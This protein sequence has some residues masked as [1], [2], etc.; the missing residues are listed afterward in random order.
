MMTRTDHAGDIEKLREV[1]AIKVSPM[2]SKAML[3]QQKTYAVAADLLEMHD[4]TGVSLDNW[5]SAKDLIEL[6][7]GH[8]ITKNGV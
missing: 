8:P 5:E 3:L 6:L 7:I 1:A 2:S 4:A